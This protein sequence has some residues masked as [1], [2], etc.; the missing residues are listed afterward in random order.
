MYRPYDKMTK[1]QLKPLYGKSKE[2]LD[3]K[4]E[5]F[6]NRRMLK[7][8]NDDIT[9]SDYVLNWLDNVH[10]VNKKPLTMERYYSTYENYIENS[11]IGKVKLKDL[12]IEFFQ[13][14][15]NK[16]KETKSES[17]VKSLHK[18]ISP[19][20]RYAAKTKRIEENYAEYIIVPQDTSI[21]KLT[22]KKRT[23][24]PLTLEQHL[25]FVDYLETHNAL[26]AALYITAVDTGIRQGELF[27][28]KLNDLDFD[29]DTISV[30]KTYA[31]VKDRK[32]KK[33]VGVVTLP[34]SKKSIRVLHMPS[35]T[36]YALLK[37]INILKEK[38]IKIGVRL[39]DESLVFCTSIGTYLDATNE[40]NN[41]KDVYEKLGISRTHTF[42]D[43]RHT[44]ATRLFELGEAP[45]T[46]QE[47]LGHANVNIT[48]N[49]YTHVLDKLKK[50]TVTKIDNIYANT[51]HVQCLKTPITYRTITEQSNDLPNV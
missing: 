23:P 19:A 3:M 51:K 39:E 41:L 36:K 18:I 22:R 46:V 10:S 34:K 20:L 8:C 15:Y 50:N 32:T 29:N 13:D 45:K 27:A 7:I 28:L 38:M 42:H 31:Y 48:L 14:W 16:L 17:I 26:H 49:T 24:A 21:E 33:M 1:K 25:K 11:D 9:L 30:T 35:H 44:Y 40:R 4:V 6:N 2:Q 47:L 37:H 43:L 12:R 5:A